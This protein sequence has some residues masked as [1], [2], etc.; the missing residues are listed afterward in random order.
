VH[1]IDENGVVLIHK[2]ISRARLMAMVAQWPACVIGME[3]CSGAHEG[4][5]RFQALGHT[6]RIMASR[7]VCAF[8]RNVL[9]FTCALTIELSGQPR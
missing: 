8:L 3:A 2:T 7:L 9:S 6:V 1:A 5:R 4:A